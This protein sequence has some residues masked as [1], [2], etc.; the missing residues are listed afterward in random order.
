M[1]SRG[2][3]LAPIASEQ[4]DAQRAR[5]NGKPW[6]KL[7]TERWPKPEHSSP[8]QSSDANSATLRSALS[9]NRARSPEIPSYENHKQTTAQKTGSCEEPEP[10]LPR[11]GH[12]PSK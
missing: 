8:T 9:L 5:R 2:S 6:L 7:K 12:K 4:V 11:R 1:L 3:Q 10:P